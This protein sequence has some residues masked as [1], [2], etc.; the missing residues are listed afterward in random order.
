MVDRLGPLG[1]QPDIPAPNGLLRGRRRTLSAGPV[2]QTGQ[3][4]A[5]PPQ[6]VALGTVVDQTVLVAR[7]LGMVGRG[8]RQTAQRL[9]ARPMR[10]QRWMPAAVLRSVSPQGVERRRRNVV[11]EVALYNE[12]N[13]DC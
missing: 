1:Q 13:T 2:E 5:A 12:I 7:G 3:A 4:R 8:G 6:P 9:I 10:L 11:A